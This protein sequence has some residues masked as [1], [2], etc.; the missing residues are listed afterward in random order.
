MKSEPRDSMYDM[1]QDI[2]IKYDTDGSG[3]LDK[4]EVLKLLDDVLLSQGRS[5]TSWAQFNRFFAEFDDNGDGVISMN[6]C[7]RFVKRFIESPNQTHIR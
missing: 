1:I 3:F 2:F 6:E 4:R 5:K 7:A